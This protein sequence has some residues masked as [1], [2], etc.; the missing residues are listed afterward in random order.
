MADKTVAGANAA[1]TSLLTGA[2]V[3]LT[4]SG[5][6]VGAGLG[7]SAQSFGAVSPSGGVA[8]NTAPLVFGTSTAA[9]GTVNGIQVTL[10]GGA[11]YMTKAIASTPVAG[12]FTVSI[13]TGA[14]TVTET[15]C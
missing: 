5:T 14:L 8:A 13:G 10:A 12:G 1:L 15:L 6:E 11:I 4:V 7:Y 3:R 9:W 2:L